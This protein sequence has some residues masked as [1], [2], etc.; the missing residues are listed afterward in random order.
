[1]KGPTVRGWKPSKI[2]CSWAGSIG[3]LHQGYQSQTPPALLL[4]VEDVPIG[5][6]HQIRSARVAGGTDEGTGRTAEGRGF[7]VK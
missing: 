3:H 4:L 2:I 7:L 5:I 6:I 1:M